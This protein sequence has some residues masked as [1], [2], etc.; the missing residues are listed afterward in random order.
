MGQIRNNTY[1][2]MGKVNRFTGPNRRMG[3]A[4]LK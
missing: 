2:K 1:R 4:F 3:A